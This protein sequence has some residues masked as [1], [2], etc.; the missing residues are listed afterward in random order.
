[1][2]RLQD[3]IR[4]QGEAVEQIKTNQ[5]ETGERSLVP[6]AAGSRDVRPVVVPDNEILEEFKTQ[7]RNY[8]ECDNNIKKLATV[9]KELQATKR[10]LTKKI[11]E[12]MAKYNIE[13]LNTK[14]GKLHY[15]V[16]TS[17]APVT[18]SSIRQRM[19]DMFGKASSVQE[20]LD[21]V[22][23]NDEKVKR[24]TLKRLKCTRETRID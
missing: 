16:T 12:F 23:T 22:F 21:Y 24:V 18:R 11:Q 19:L 1:M 8:M 20:L 14:D 7:V 5:K 13:D 15:K 10:E 9:K 2:D 3:Y 4:Q 17:K 6:V